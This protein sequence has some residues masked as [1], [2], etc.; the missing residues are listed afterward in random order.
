MKPEDAA[1]LEAV[2]AQ[3]QAP[4]T[5]VVRQMILAALQQ[6]R[7]AQAPRPRVNGEH[8]EAV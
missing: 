5:V 2:A 3:L 6:I 8:R 4:V 1:E 7:G